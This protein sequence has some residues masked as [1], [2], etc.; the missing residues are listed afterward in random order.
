[1]T[2]QTQNY[3]AH[4]ATKAEIKEA[5]A[6]LLSGVSSDPSGVAEFT[7][8]WWKRMMFKHS[9]GPRAMG[10]QMDTFVVPNPDGPEGI[11]GYLSVQLRG[12][13]ASAFEWGVT[14]PLAQADGQAILRAL[15]DAAVAKV[16]D[17]GDYD[18]FYLG[19][20]ADE[21]GGIQVLESEDFYE[22]DYQLVQMTAPL[23]LTLPSDAG[24]SAGVHFVPK[25]ARAYKAEMERLLRLDYPGDADAADTAAAMH[26]SIL[27]NPKI[28]EIELDVEDVGGEGMGGKRESVGF[29]QF[30]R[31]K[32]EQRVLYAL[33]PRLWGTETEVGIL[34]TALA[35][36]LHKP[37]R[38]R[39][40]TFSRGHLEASRP[41]LEALGL[42]WAE[43]VW[44]R[45]V[46]AW[47]E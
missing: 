19:L 18:H 22:A 47:E 25:L 43:S 6:L 38:L 40:R 2:E 44:R 8:S 30:N 13:A 15:L 14:R 32:D 12:S 3:T 36:Y 27:G 7:A 29:L 23:P 46:V 41:A 5:I 42:T 26:L 17:I 34:R 10:Q 37:G 31:Y 9:A 24:S 33:A 16:E 39:L 28:M 21:T 45:Y 11:L 35:P 4:K 20:M 1:M